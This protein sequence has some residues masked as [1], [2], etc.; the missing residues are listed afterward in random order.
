[1]I[2]AATIAGMISFGETIIEA[3]NNVRDH[4]TR[5]LKYLDYPI[6]VQ[7]KKTNRL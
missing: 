2:S 6:K 7:N 4:T 5:V 3:P 1:M